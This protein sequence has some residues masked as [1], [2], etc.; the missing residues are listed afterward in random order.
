MPGFVPDQG[1]T[2]QLVAL[3]QQLQAQ[4]TQLKVS[5]VPRVVYDS[6]GVIRAGFGQLS[7]PFGASYTGEY[8]MAVGD[9]LGNVHEVNPAITRPA[10]SGSTTSTTFVDT[11]WGTLTAYIG[12]SGSAIIMLSARLSLTTGNQTAEVSVGVD[13]VTPS[14]LSDLDLSNQ[15]V[16]PIQAGVAA[17]FLMT[18]LTPQT[19]H[20]FNLYALSSNGSSITWVKLNL[21]VWP[22]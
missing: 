8:G 20:T 9:P 11:G 14:G 12:G 3:F 6:N 15:N 5:F 16:Q 10:S 19:E 13:G 21:I 17:N 4:I 22:V 1:N 2:A 18:G 7:G